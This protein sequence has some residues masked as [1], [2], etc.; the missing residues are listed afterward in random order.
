MPESL[1]GSQ[2]LFY[3]GNRTGLVY[4]PSMELHEDP[5]GPHPECPQRIAS[6]Y[7]ELERAGLVKRCVSVPIRQVTKQE[8]RAVH[9]EAYLTEMESFVANVEPEDLLAQSRKFNSIY[10][11]SY[12]M[13]A[14]AIAAGATLALTEQV[15]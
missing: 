11:N 15:M 5:K 12:S 9:E 7:K 10:M 14:A 13:Q 1:H 3:L 6:I 2:I 4:D 8:L